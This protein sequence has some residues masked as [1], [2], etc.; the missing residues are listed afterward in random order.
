MTVKT[1]RAD[2]RQQ[3]AQPGLKACF[4]SLLGWMEGPHK[5]SLGHIRNEVQQRKTKVDEAFALAGLLGKGGG[6]IT[7]QLEQPL[8]ALRS[9]GR[10]STASAACPE[11]DY[12]KEDLHAPALHWESPC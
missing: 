3:E 10:E 1:N 9:R 6:V 5:R 4:A 11:Q 8:E 12:S 2:Y 7:G